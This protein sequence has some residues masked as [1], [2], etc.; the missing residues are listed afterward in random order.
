[1]NLCVDMVNITLHDILFALRHQ[2]NMII[3]LVN[4]LEVM[5]RK[6][7]GRGERMSQVDECLTIWDW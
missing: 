2:T 4:Y 6:D 5:D 3:R 7:R 1:M